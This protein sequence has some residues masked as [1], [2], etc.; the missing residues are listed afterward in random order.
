[1]DIK[2][3]LTKI[4]ELQKQ[5]IL[6]QS[7]KTFIPILVSTPALLISAWTFFSNRKSKKRDVLRSLISE[8]NSAKLRVEEISLEMAPL[9]GK[10]QA[11]SISTEEEN[12]LNILNTTMESRNDAVLNVIENCCKA[13]YSNQVIKKDFRNEFFKDVELFVDSHKNKYTPPFTTYPRTVEF[14]E[15]ICKQR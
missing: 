9:L 12:A 1:M 7:I 11:N 13:Y 14:Y 6:L 15:N 8:F 4:Q 2:T 3:A 5:I 10:K